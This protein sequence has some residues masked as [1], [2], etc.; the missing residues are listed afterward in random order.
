[1]I[2][3]FMAQLKRIRTEQ[4]IIKNSNDYSHRIIKLCHQLEK[5]LII[6]KNGLKPLW[7]WAKFYELLGLLPLEKD[8]HSIE[9]ARNAIA[10][11]LQVKKE[12]REFDEIEKAQQLIKAQHLP[13]PSETNA[14]IFGCLSLKK[15]DLCFHSFEDVVLT[16]HSIRN[17]AQKEVRR[18]DVVK[19]IELASMCPSACNRQPFKVYIINSTKK[20]ELGLANQTNANKYLIVTGI[21]DAFALNEFNDW[22]VSASI[23]CG[24]LSLTLHYCGLGNCLMR[25]NLNE[26]TTYN[27]IL[28]TYLG[29]PNNEKMCLEIAVGYYDDESYITRSFRKPIGDIIGGSYEEN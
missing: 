20:E 16:R 11:F 19:A 3:P 13:I 26:E 27:S 1:M 2:K 25:M 4:K 23:F 18:E 5:G 15:K 7:G 14:A 6:R 8:H 9:L 10:C 12:E 17:F 24:Y 29:I 28:R 21:V 22:L